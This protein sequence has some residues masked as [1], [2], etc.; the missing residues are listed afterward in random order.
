[1]KDDFEKFLDNQLKN[2]EFRKEWESLASEYAIMTSKH[3]RILFIGNSHT[4]M[5][6]L[7]ARVKA[8]ALEDGYSCEVTM[9]AHGGWYLCEHVKEPQ[10][11]FNV[12]YGDYDFIV[13]QEHSHPF[14]RI[15]DYRSAVKTI[16]SWADKAGSRVV[17]YGTWARKDDRSSQDYMNKV[18]RDIADKNVAIL[19]PVGESWWDHIDARPDIELY[20]ED[21]AHASSAGTE[22]AANIIWVSIRS[23]SPS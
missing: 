18:N 15:D 8:I 5:N 16:S 4:Y 21:G 9:L 23:I 14:D 13:L 12:M 22:F 3:L 19:A 1:M 10:T 17:I 6:D 11:K 20:D 2:E 7:P